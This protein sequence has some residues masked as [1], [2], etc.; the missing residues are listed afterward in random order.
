M[1]E[2]LNETDSEHHEI[3]SSTTKIH[4][5]DLAGHVCAHKQIAPPRATFAKLVSGKESC[6]II[7]WSCYFY[8]NGVFTM[9][10]MTRGKWTID[11]YG[12][13]CVTHGGVITSL[14]VLA[15]A[16][17]GKWNRPS[18]N[19]FYLDG[20]T[21]NLSVDN[22]VPLHEMTREMYEH[23]PN[24]MSHLN[25]KMEW[26]HILRFQKEYHNISD[27]TNITGSRLSRDLDKYILTAK[28]RDLIKKKILEHQYLPRGSFDN[29]YRA[30]DEHYR[31]A[32]Y[33][34]HLCR[35]SAMTSHNI[36]HDE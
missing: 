21:Y 17:G 33:Y 20:N 1:T 31:R 30:I 18:F 36:A 25:H 34:S 12:N 3:A 23:N 35:V 4:L 5:R 29:T 15:M 16:I 27:P 10:K 32:V 9:P 13:I 11:R 22:L 26:Q 2:Q 19:W 7:S 8:S 14:P 28:S 6:W 24:M